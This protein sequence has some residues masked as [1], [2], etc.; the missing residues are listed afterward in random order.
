MRKFLLLALLMGSTVLFAQNKKIATGI[1][2][3]TS[4]LP[5]PGVTVQLKNS[6]I[7]T[8]TDSSGH[9]VIES[10]NPEKDVLQFS[11]VGYRPVEEKL[12]LGGEM[13]ILMTQ[14]TKTGDEVVVVAFGKQKKTTMVGS[15]TTINPKELKGP[16]SNLTSMLAGRLAG[17]IAFQQSGEP[18]KDNANFFIRGLGNFGTGKRDPLIYIDGIE[19]TTDDLARLNA[20]NIENFSLLKDATA[21][22]MY[23]ARGGNGVILITTKQGASGQTRFNFRVENRISGNTKLYKLAD[24]ITYMRLANEA[25]TTRDPLA[26]AP[27]DPNKIDNT[28][29][30]RDPVLYP[31]NDWMKLLVKNYT[32]NLSAN[33]DLSG[34]TEKARFFVSMTYDENNGLMREQDL[35]NFRS[36]IKLRSYSLMSNVNLKLTNTTDALISI[37]T[38]F[39]DYHGPIGGGAAVFTAASTSNPVAYPAIYP[40]RYLPYIQHPLFGNAFVPG[41][42]NIALY[43]NPYAKA[44]SG[45]QQTNTAQLTP[46]ITINQNLKDILPGLTASAMAYTTRQSYFDVSRQYSPFYY[47]ASIINGTPVLSLLNDVRNSIQIGDVPTEYLS[48]SP[49]EKKVSTVLWGQAA[50]NY[51]GRFAEKHSV[52]AS[53]ITYAQ[54]SLSGN[55]DN[56]QQSLPARNLSF[57]GRATYGYD[58]R[59]LTEFSFGYNASERFDPKNRWGFFPSIGLGWVLTNETFFEPLTNVISNLKLRGTYG[60]SGND[61]IGRPED[62]FFY[63]SNVS[64]AGPMYYFGEN[65]NYL[66]NTIR[67]SRYANPNITWETTNQINLG[68]DLSLFR[69]LNIIADVYKKQV[70]GILLARNATVPTSMGLQANVVANTGRTDVK[71]LEVAVD[72]TSQVGPDFTVISRGNFTYAT[73]KVVQTEEPS[74]PAGLEYLKKA[75]NSSDQLYGLIAERLFTDDREV[76]NSPQQSF[77]G[78]VMGGDIKYR[79]INGDGKITSLDYVPIGWPK[80]PEITYG[81]GGTVAYKGLIDVSFFFQG[82]AR[83]SFL[84]DAGSALKGDGSGNVEG[85]SPFVVNPRTISGNNIIVAQSGLLDV[86]ARDHWSEDNRNPYAFWPRL[87]DK[88]IPNNALASTWWLQNGDFLRLKQIDIGYN[89]DARML[90][91]YGLTFSRIY[92]SA[93]NLFTWSRFKLWD[94]EMAGNG[95][96]YPLQRV[97]SLGVRLGF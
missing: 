17:I 55:A 8:I 97:F 22:A 53:I 65:F 25:A 89:P 67:T 38:R 78:L 93:Q 33:F 46:Q 49:G 69:K 50:L 64:L 80:V 10:L 5:L 72:Y 43:L 51:A 88:V 56:L 41:T 11:F 96:G 52:G 1:V 58:E 54:S 90:K 2:K 39:D 15:V 85:V 79:D 95:L 66:R 9:F 16:S 83:S 7:V 74:Y 94:V 27:Y 20:D 21:T 84:I 68:M 82:S 32:N 40:Q 59:Y 29:A 23:G 28:A 35:N 45:Y 81:F 42:N 71:G 75:G 6:P 19:S 57:S 70:K 24:N 37:K 36:N 86:I 62:R 61:A 3:D 47:S 63:L 77:G 14:E 44:V 73:T 31:N 13:Q 4:R 92:L 18:G 60:R 30:G 87:S 26:A 48:Y 34:G 76:A 12:T 91:K